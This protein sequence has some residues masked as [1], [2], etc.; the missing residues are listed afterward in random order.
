MN[1]ISTSIETFSQFLS[2]KAPGLLVLL[3]YFVMGWL[4][5]QTTIT[6]RDI[7]DLRLADKVLESNDKAI[8]IKLQVVE[9]DVRELK[10]DMKEVRKDITEM[11]ADI[12]EMKTDIATIKAVVLKK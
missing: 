11:K 9:E 10:Q 4:V 12:A 6:Q 5:V 1:Q 3:M 8:E 7:N 2:T